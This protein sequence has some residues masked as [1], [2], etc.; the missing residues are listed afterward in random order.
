MKIEWPLP[1]MGRHETRHPHRQADWR[2][3]GNV[4]TIDLSPESIRDLEVLG[5][6]LMSGSAWRPPA[7]GTRVGPTISLGLAIP[8]RRPDGDYDLTFGV[9]CGETCGSQHMAVLRHDASG[10]RVLSSMMRSIF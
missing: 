10:W 7:A 8:T 3:L 5:F 4:G 1:A 9:W 2:T 6:Q